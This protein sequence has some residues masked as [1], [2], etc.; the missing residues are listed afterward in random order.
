MLLGN[1]DFTSH[2]NSNSVNS[3]TDKVRIEGENIKILQEISQIIQVQEE[4][5]IG[6]LTVN[7]W[8][9]NS[10]KNFGG[11]SVNLQTIEVPYWTFGGYISSHFEHASAKTRYGGLSKAITSNTLGLST[12]SMEYT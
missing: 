6:Y 2:K 7:K 1:L 3:K 12:G 5:L 8:G 9:S 10:K 11:S 4:I